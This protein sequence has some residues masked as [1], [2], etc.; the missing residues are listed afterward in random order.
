[1]PQ[2]FQETQFLHDR[3]GD[4]Y[5]CAAINCNMRD[6]IPNWAVSYYDKFGAQMRVQM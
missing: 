4:R 6:T 5:D 3:L 1:M 2:G